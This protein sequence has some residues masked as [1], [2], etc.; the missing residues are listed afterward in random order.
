MDVPDWRASAIKLFGRIVYEA[1][2]I[3]KLK[4]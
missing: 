4:E 2:N 1:S 3:I